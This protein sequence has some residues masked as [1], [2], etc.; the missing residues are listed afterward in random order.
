MSWSRRVELLNI[1]ARRLIGRGAIRLQGALPVD[2]DAAAIGAAELHVGTALRDIV[3]VNID[4]H[5]CPPANSPLG[6]RAYSNA[7]RTHTTI[8]CVSRA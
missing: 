7:E 3:S 6:P 1:E 5:D 4:L 8:R 2:A